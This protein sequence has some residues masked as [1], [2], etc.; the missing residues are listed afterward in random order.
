MRCLGDKIP[1]AQQIDR[2]ANQLEEQYAGRILPV[3][4]EVTR[5]WGVLSADRGRPVVATL[6][7]TTAKIH[8]LTLVT[9][10]TAHV[11]GLRLHVVNPWAEAA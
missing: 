10:N 2:F 3:D 1:A 9:R 7:A 11:Q 4:T 5:L 6:I 8:D